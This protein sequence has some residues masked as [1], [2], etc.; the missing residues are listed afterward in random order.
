MTYNCFR[1]KSA[2]SSLVDFSNWS[3][4]IWD[5]LQIKKN[6]SEIGFMYR[7]KPSAKIILG[8]WSKWSIILYCILWRKFSFWNKTL[9][10]IEPIDVHQCKLIILIAS[11]LHTI[12]I[13]IYVV[14]QQRS[15]PLPFNNNYLNNKP[16]QPTQ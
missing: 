2:V 3:N 14:K 16:K 8:I 10:I 5:F 7:M 15:I 1:V 13:Y 12:N 11:A 6:N 4:W 9:I